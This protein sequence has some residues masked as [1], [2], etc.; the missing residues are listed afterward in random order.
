MSKTLRDLMLFFKHW[1]QNCKFMNTLGV[2]AF[3]ME[4]LNVTVI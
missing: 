1:G 4:E 2:R 3:A